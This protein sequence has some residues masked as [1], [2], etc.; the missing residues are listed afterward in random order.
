MVSSQMYLEAE[1]FAI[2]LHRLIDKMDPEFNYRE[3]GTPCE[4]DWQ[5]YHPEKSYDAYGWLLPV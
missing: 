5:F 2:L 1:R 4:C 3:T